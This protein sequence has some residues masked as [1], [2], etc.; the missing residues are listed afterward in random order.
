LES[1]VLGSL[2][3]GD[4][5]VT[6]DGRLNIKI[7]RDTDV[8]HRYRW[9]ILDG[10]RALACSP[11]SYAIRREAEVDVGKAMLGLAIQDDPIQPGSSWASYH[12]PPEI[13]KRSL[14]TEGVDAFSAFEVGQ[15]ELPV[16]VDILLNG[17]EP[18]GRRPTDVLADR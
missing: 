2:I 12:K 11:N 1:T 4:R 15:S 9:P 7:I 5:K 10:G 3:G 18:N 6:D 13:A 14:R 8:A 16:E 17:L